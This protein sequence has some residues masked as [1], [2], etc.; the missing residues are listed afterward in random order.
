MW[1]N[2]FIIDKTKYEELTNSKLIKKKIHKTLVI[3]WLS[4]PQTIKM[5]GLLVSCHHGYWF[6]DI[7]GLMKLLYM[8]GFVSLEDFWQLNQFLCADVVHHHYRWQKI[9]IEKQNIVAPSWWPLVN[10]WL[11]GSNTEPHTLKSLDTLSS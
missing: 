7:F 1:A 6:A 9:S 8:W 5:C 4:E 10:N 2:K 3:N 11:F